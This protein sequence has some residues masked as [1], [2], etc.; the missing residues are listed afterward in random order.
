MLKQAQSERTLFFPLELQGVGT[1]EVESMKSYVQRLAL[2]H[3]LNQTTLFN[4]LFERR[5]LEGYSTSKST[6]RLTDYWA[7]HGASKLGRE[8]S[9][10]LSEATGVDMATSTLTRFATLF[11]PV[12][13]SNK[14]GFSHYCSLCVATPSCGD[15]PY[16]RLLWMVGGVKACPHHRV[17]LRDASLCGAPDSA[18]LEKGC[19]PSLEGV[20]TLCGSIGFRC[21]EGHKPEA[22]TDVE[23]WQA[24]QVAN[25]LALAPSQSATLSVESMRAGLKEVV[26]ARFDGK[27][28]QP[29]LDAG[30]AR[31][32]LWSWLEGKFRP[33]IGGLLKFCA[34]AECDLV[35]L[36]Q[37]RF[38]HR[39][40]PAGN[41]AEL[42]SR[43]AYRR[44]PLGVE[45]I[46][47][48]I[49]EAASMEPPL[50]GA[51]LSK[52]LGM[53]MKEFRARFAAEYAVLKQARLR[54]SREASQQR[55]VEYE[56]RFSSAAATLIAQGRPVSRK[57]L[58][59][60]AGMTVYLVPGNRKR[61]LDAVLERIASQAHA[62]EAQREA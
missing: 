22:A 11:S 25:L 59:V 14:R 43:R 48:R 47:A 5:P 40:A 28:V 4:V 62:G 39:P 57:S 38:L 56:R 42:P 35:A 18:R 16:G 60:E 29:S 13:L 37:G 49:L 23:V 30:L 8:L 53:D 26:D 27:S 1:A 34:H 33:S 21:M 12:G 50:S 55:Y 54:H 6:S 32:V 20:C 36:L 10:R 7:V 45:E 52:S 46:R 15:L 2:S 51:Q 19:Q 24:E 17:R 44:N 31:A 3:R 58:Q 41:S 61:A 9:D